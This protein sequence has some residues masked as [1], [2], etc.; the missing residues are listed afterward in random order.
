MNYTEN[1]SWISYSENAKDKLSVDSENMG[2]NTPQYPH[3]G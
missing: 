1:G 2:V 3:D